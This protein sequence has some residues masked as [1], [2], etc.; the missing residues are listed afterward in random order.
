M[1]LQ[2]LTKKAEQGDIDAQYELG[3]LYRSGKHRNY[4]AAL[5]WLLKAAEQGHAASQNAVGEIFLW[6]KKKQ[7]RDEKKAFYWFLKAAEQGEAQ[8]YFNLSKVYFEG[9]GC[10]ENFEESTYWLQ[11]AAE[12]NI[13]GAQEELEKRYSYIY[14]SERDEK[15]YEKLFGIGLD[16]KEDPYYCPCYSP[17]ECAWELRETDEERQSREKHKK[18]LEKSCQSTDIILAIEETKGGIAYQIK[19]SGRCDKVL[20][21]ANKNIYKV[22]PHTGDPFILPLLVSR[23]ADKYFKHFYSNMRQMRDMQ[24]RLLTFSKCERYEDY[25]VV[26]VPGTFEGWKVSMEN[27]KIKLF[28]ENF[29]KNYKKED[30]NHSL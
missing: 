1:K 9:K 7:L 10:A 5:L 27:E 2:D 29:K 14:R 8:A 28:V 13:Y 12:E 17:Y 23:N 3:C 26:E 15:E 19:Y 6:N 11:K 22:P 24:G 21:L 25:F 20:M 4:S 30:S 16:A 18:D